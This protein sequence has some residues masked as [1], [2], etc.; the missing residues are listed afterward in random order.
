MENKL[1]EILV[2][3]P[4][5]TIWERQNLSNLKFL[6]DGSYLIRKSM[7]LKSESLEGYKE[8]DYLFDSRA[9][10]MRESEISQAL[11]EKLKTIIHNVPEIKKKVIIYYPNGSESLN[12]Y[13][14]YKR[15][16]K[17]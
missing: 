10:S 1:I 17:T 9:I 15:K 5:Q 16:Y 13:E 4:Y 6:E 2:V 12:I 11:I 3:E 14:R 7:T 8:N